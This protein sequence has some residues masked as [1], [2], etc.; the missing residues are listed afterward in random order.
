MTT[1]YACAGLLHPI[2]WVYMARCCLVSLAVLI[3]WQLRHNGCKL[4]NSSLAPPCFNGTMWSTIVAAVFW[5]CLHIGSLVRTYLLTF[6]QA[7]SYPRSLALPSCSRRF[8]SAR[9]LA[10]A[11]RSSRLAWHG[12][13]SLEPF[14]LLPLQPLMQ[15]V[16][17]LDGIKVSQLMHRHVS[18]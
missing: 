9:A 1:H 14:T 11:I 15:N 8:C 16:C 3:A 12:V 18:Q 10:L 13:Q 5:Q 2:L 4:F 6:A 17:T 7:Q